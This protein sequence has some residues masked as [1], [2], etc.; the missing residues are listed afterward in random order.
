MMEDEVLKRSMFSK[1]MT[2]AARSSGIMAGFDDAGMDDM[3]PEEPEEQMSPMARTPQN[4][5]ILMNTLRGDMR[6]VDARMQELAQMVGEEAAME[7]PPEVLALLQAQ[8]GQQGQGGIG[9]LPQSAGMAPGAAPQGAMPGMPGMPPAPGGMPPQG[10]APQGPVGAPPFPQGESAPQQFSHGGAVEPA[11]PDG[12]PP[13]HAF[14]G[15]FVSPL[16]R[17]AQM[18]ADKAA[19]LGTEANIA[20]GQLMSRGFPQQFPAIIENLRGPGGKFIADQAMKYPTLTQHMGNMGAK[21]A[22]EYP[23]AASALSSVTQPVVAGAATLGASI[24]VIRDMM[25]SEPLSA[26]EQQ[27]RDY[28]ISQIPTT[29]ELTNLPSTTGASSTSDSK[30][31]AAPV[32]ESV[33]AAAAE[34]GGKEKSTADFIKDQAAKPSGAAMGAVTPAMSEADT[35][36]SKYKE[37]GP[38]FK[39]LLGDDQESMRANAM[40]LLADAGFKYASARPTAGSTP[41]SVFAEAFGDLPKGMAALASQAQDRKIKINTAALQQAVSD[42]TT[43]KKEAQAIRMEVLKGDYRI[44]AEQAKNGGAKLEDGGAGLVVATSPKGGYM[45]VSI[46][47]KNPTVQSAVSSRWTLNDANPFVEFRGQA[48]TSVETDKGERTKLTSTLRSLDNSLGML[49]NL[50]GDYAN[51]YGPGAWFSDKVNNMLVPVMPS[52]VVRPDVN[53]AD[54]ATRISTGM[55]KL[56][57]SIA[58]A[59]DG[60][61]VAVQ[62]QEWARETA[63]GISN[64]TAFFSDK[65][66]AA[67]Q[68]NSMETM[69]RNSR[70]QVLTQLGYESGDYVMRTPNTGTKSDPFVIPADPKAQSQMFNF[71]GSTIGR[72]QNPSATVYLKLPNGS[73][74][75]FNPGQLQGLIKQ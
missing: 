13:M 45:G 66:L 39:E 74:Q 72:I 58:A 68:F 26:E 23:R 25:S 42:V 46:D 57:K 47:P 44:L 31:P 60:G 19:M 71:L 10:A 4:P 1:P 32:P 64:P 24:P 56:V 36:R 16:T 73:T 62:E 17:M 6:S 14:L 65:E 48:P 15:A 27:K 35:I 69:L 59:N 28:L 54:T 43:A 67:K 7:T 50:K 40:L 11:T 75:A 34:E 63:K 52:A 38:L 8:L 70:Q 3:Q 12:M 29:H 9:A 49:D 41:F 30:A 55:D 37:Y 2:K 20:G 51:A 5:E 53:L 22:D 33:V 61:R 21:L 18:G